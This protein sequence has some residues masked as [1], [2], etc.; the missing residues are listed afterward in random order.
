V[1]PA[2]ALLPAFFELR[3]ED[4]EVAWSPTDHVLSVSGDLLATG[5]PFPTET[6]ASPALGLVVTATVLESSRDGTRVTLQL[7]LPG[8]EH[9]GGPPAPVTGVAVVV[10]SFVDVVGGPPPVRHAFE[11]RSLEGTVI[12]WSTSPV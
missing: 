12:G 4:I 11:V 2:G 8:T 5:G 1:T 6:T 9:H 3:G 7:H 10:R